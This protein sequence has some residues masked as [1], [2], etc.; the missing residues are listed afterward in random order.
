MRFAA[1]ATLGPASPPGAL[2]AATVVDVLL[3]VEYKVIAGP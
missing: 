2:D 3:Y 1:A